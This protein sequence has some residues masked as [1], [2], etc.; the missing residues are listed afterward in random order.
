MHRESV[1]EGVEYKWIVCDFKGNRMHGG[2][3][4]QYNG[5]CWKNQFMKVSNPNA[6]END[7]RINS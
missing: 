7:K 5:K 4:L 3:K 1:H 2:I 6:M